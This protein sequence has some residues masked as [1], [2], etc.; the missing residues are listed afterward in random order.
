MLFLRTLGAASVRL[1]PRPS[2]LGSH[3][4][5]C[6]TVVAAGAAGDASRG[7]KP[8]RSVLELREQLTAS[9]LRAQAAELRLSMTNELNQAKVA[10]AEAK[11][12]AKA[13]AA[14]AKAEVAVGK[15]Q[16][17]ALEL[18][19]SRGKLDMRSVLG[20][21]FGLGCLC[22]ATHTERRKYTGGGGLCCVV[23][24]PLRN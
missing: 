17:L 23:S 2:V 4:L 5:V 1:A 8:K 12:E 7:A 15:M 18:A 3:P 13:V 10:E 22:W 6:R 9:M 21:W 14:E 16:F 11:A 24:C 19:R 20:R